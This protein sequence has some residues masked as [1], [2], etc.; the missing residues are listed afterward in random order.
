VVETVVNQV[1][2]DV[3]T[4][5]VELLKYISGINQTL[6]KNIVAYRTEHGSFKNRKEIKKVSRMGP[7]AYEQSIGFLRIPNGEYL[8]D[9]TSIHPESYPATIELLQ[10][11]GIKLDQLGEKSVQDK[12]S[13]V[14]TKILS[15]K[16]SVGVETLEDIKK[17]LL[18]PGRDMRDDMPPV[19]LRSDVLSLDD[20]RVGMK[21]TGT[22]R[23][24]IDFGAFVD[25]GVKEDG[26]IHISKLAKKFIKHPSEVLSVGDIV[27]VTVISIDEKKKRIGLSLIEEEK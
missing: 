20:I 14:N 8:L 23:N 24:V 7:K 21:L 26:M 1:G 17:S 22:V 4:A 19:L 13:N 18:A 10:A 6:A 2:V 12:I 15:E 16:V 11:L 25:I 3:N 9:N 5:S 27:E